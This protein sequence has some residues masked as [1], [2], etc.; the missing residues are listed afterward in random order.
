MTASDKERLDKIENKLRL[1]ARSVETIQRQMDK[2]LD[3]IEKLVTIEKKRS[4]IE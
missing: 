4:K 3:V 1:L 2:M